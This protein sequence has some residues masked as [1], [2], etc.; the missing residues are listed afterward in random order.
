MAASKNRW[1]VWVGVIALLLFAPG[2]LKTGTSTFVDQSSAMGR[3]VVCGQG[4]SPPTTVK[5]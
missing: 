5:K 4:V 1:K 3:G 2:L